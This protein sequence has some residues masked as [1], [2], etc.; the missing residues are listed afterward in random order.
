MAWNDEIQEAAYNSPSGKRQTFI[1]ENVSRETDL[2]TASFVF[3]EL[4]GALIQSLGLG[5]RTFPLKCIFSGASCNKEA[6]SFEKL[7]SERGH[8]ILEHPVYGK[9]NVVPT[10]KIKRTDN[11]LDGANE[12]CVEVTF[13]ETLVDKE[14]PSSEVATA[15]KL[16]AAMDEYENSAAADFAGN[17]YTD[18]IED[19]M[20]L[21]AAMKSNANSTF[22]G[23]EKM[24]KAA[25]KNKKRANLF[26][27]YDSAKRFINSIIDNVDKIGTFAN[28]VATTT[29]KMI[30][31][32]SQIT[33]DAFSKLA[34]YQFMI[35]DIANNVKADPFGTKAVTNQWAAATLA[36]G[37]MIA[38]LSYGVAK[39]AAEQNSS[40]P[41]ESSSSTEG[42]SDS[43]IN[44]GFASRSDVLETAAQIAA[45]FAE[46]SAYIDSQNKKNA[47]VD[48]GETY[49]K[50]LN[51]VT[52]SLRSLEET[53]FNLPVTR[54]ITL[55]RDRQLFELLAELYGKDGFNKQDQFINDNKLTADEIVLIPM[56]RKVRYYA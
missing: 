16:D 11:I 8:G 9:I 39:T 12:S 36:W 26:Q 51:V 42:D 19:K 32:P 10:G 35:R 34:G 17:I 22:K 46:Y 7:L 14:E 37:S 52:Y 47:F 23:V 24:I 13:S 50:L 3:P 29:I 1:Y 15:D 44:C 45:S 48:T 18:S 21:R 54:I 38:A 49:E 4:D 33:S 25:P 27:W 20:Q 6:D 56:G 28:E 31:L 40:Q 55:D 43:D 30:R 53:S 5:G 2:K 41:E